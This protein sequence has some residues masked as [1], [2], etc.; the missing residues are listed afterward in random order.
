MKVKSV[1]TVKGCPHCGST[2]G[3][4]GCRVCPGLAV[5]D[6]CVSRLCHTAMAAVTEGDRERT[7]SMINRTKRGP[8]FRGLPKRKGGRQ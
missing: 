6:R 2:C 8:L 3:V 7:L 1:R 5:C 4:P